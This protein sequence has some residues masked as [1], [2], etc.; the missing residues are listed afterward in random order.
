MLDTS[1]YTDHVVIANHSYPVCMRPIL[2]KQGLNICN[3]RPDELVHRIYAPPG[4]HVKVK[5][6]AKNLLA[7]LKLGETV[8]I[9]PIGASDLGIVDMLSGYPAVDDGWGR[10]LITSLK[11][12]TSR[13]STATRFSLS[14]SLS[15]PIDKKSQIGSSLD[16]G[17]V[18]FSLEFEV[19]DSALKDF[20]PE[21]SD[22]STMLGLI[23]S[24]SQPSA[25]E[26]RSAGN[27]TP[28]L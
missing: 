28:R 3:F 2:D 1:K 10:R 17:A 18:P 26:G 14:G 8:E 23:C 11:I 4:P 21:E 6:P 19:Q 16:P 12:T 9:M 25:P 7:A 13:S 27:P 24:T 15:E 22:R 5:M 20:L